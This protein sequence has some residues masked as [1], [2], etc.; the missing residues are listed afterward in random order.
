MATCPMRHWLS[1][2]ALAA[3]LALLLALPASD[4]S[5]IQ[6]VLQAFERLGGLAGVTVLVAPLA[7]VLSLIGGGYAAIAG[8][9][10][11][12]LLGAAVLA[13]AAWLLPGRPWRAG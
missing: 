7:L 9:P 13:A 11:G 3:S 5:V 8:H 4:I 6:G 10:A 1:G 12:A 2:L